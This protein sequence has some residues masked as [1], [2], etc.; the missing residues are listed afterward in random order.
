M[1]TEVDIFS[2]GGAVATTGRRDDGFTA[3][4]TGSSS[5]SKRI[6]SYC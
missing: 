4:I 2:Q 1:S 5:T 3:N 6:C